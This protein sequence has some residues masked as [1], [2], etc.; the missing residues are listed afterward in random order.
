MHCLC[1]YRHRSYYPIMDGQSHQ[2]PCS[3]QSAYGHQHSLTVSGWFASHGDYKAWP[4]PTET[5][6]TLRDIELPPDFLQ[7]S[8]L[9]SSPKE[10]PI[11]GERSSELTH[12]SADEIFNA[13]TTGLTVDAM[14][15]SRFSQGDMTS[16]AE[17]TGNL[18]P[19]YGLRFPIS[20]GEVNRLAWAH[21]A[22]EL[23]TDIL[24]RFIMWGKS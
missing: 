6:D 7:F 5:A 4:E 1:R 10:T 22:E 14:E 2:Y 9:M 23:R 11:T 3:F 18:E 21:L 15:G 8:S 13:W 17:S 12:D 24:T 16:E 20:N 19:R